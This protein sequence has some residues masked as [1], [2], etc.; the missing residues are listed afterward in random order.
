[1]WCR[2][3]ASWGVC[4]LQPRNVS[5]WREVGDKHTVP[6][7]N[8]LFC[9]SGREA[10]AASTADIRVAISNFILIDLILTR[11]D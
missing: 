1:M 5:R 6:V 9:S 10:V 11:D 7:G 8:A 4:M 2:G 3:R